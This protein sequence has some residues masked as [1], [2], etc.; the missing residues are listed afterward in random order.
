MCPPFQGISW[1]SFGPIERG[2]AKAMM[3]EAT[4]GWK[5]RGKRRGEEAGGI[6]DEGQKTLA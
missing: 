4:E 3:G 2:K 6:R 1:E 5:E